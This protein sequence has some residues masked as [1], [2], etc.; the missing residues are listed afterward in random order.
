MHKALSDTDI[1]KI[2]GHDTKIIKY[3]ELS[4]LADLNQSLPNTLDYCIIIYED[5]IDHGHPNPMVNLS[6]S[7]AS[8][9]PR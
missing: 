1:R 8:L 3:S 4:Q 5:R 2:L 7:I 9:K 6:I